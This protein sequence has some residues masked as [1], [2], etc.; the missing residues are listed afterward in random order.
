M[1]EETCALLRLLSSLLSYPEEEGP[2]GLEEAVNAMPVARLHGRAWETCASFLARTDRIPLVQRMETYTE[3]FDLSPGACLD[4]TRHRWPEEPA[5]RNATAHLHEIYREEGYACVAAHMPD[6][7]PVLLEF[8]SVCSADTVRWIAGTY[9]DSIA[10]LA[11]RLG[12][13]GS[14]YACLFDLTLSLFDWLQVPEQEAIW[15][16]T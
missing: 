14:P 13:S 16:G 10:V 4:L 6:H 5:R 15:T 8:L 7:L 3:T 9:R 1:N 2:T 12:E 11:R